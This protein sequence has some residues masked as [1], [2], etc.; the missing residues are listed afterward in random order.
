MEWFKRT[1]T[2]K[3]KKNQK[4][5]GLEE[6]GDKYVPWT[7]SEEQKTYNRF[8]HFFSKFELKKLLKI[9]N[10]IEFKITGGPTE[11]DNFFIFAR[12]PNLMT[13]Y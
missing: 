5:I 2:V 11:K 8:Y 7:L 1:F 10:V 13:N 12:K 9:F 6:F 3:F 4:I